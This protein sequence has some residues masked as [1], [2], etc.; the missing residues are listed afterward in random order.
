M[1]FPISFVLLL[2]VGIIFTVSRAARRLFVPLGQ[3]AVVGEMA[4]GLMLGPS[5]FGWLMPRVSA[6]LFAPPSLP[7]LTALSKAGL[8]LFM[9]LVGL[10]LDSPHLDARKHVAIV[11]SATSII[12]PFVLGVL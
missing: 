6:A 10:R 1:G 3:P 9:F 5:C 8:G 2:Q 4:A 7:P 12:V 11:T